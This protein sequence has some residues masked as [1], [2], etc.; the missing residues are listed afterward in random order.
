LALTV[1][2]QVAN[3]LVLPHT[4]TGGRTKR[5]ADPSFGKLLCPY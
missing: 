3:T 1:R 4:L 5:D 2:D